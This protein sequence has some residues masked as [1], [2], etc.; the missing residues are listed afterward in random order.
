M[1]GSAPGVGQSGHLDFAQYKHYE[2]CAEAHRTNGGSVAVRSV[3]RGVYVFSVMDGN[4]C[5]NLSIIKG[6]TRF[7]GGV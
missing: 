2:R 5:Y 4:L 7:H 1:E 6:W 3:M